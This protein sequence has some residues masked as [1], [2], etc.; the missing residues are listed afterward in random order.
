MLSDR[1]Q[2]ELKERRW[3]GKKIILAVSGGA[4]SMVM[5]HLF[6]G[7]GCPVAIAHCN[8]G[9]RGGESEGDESLVESWAQ[10]QGIPF[11]KKQFHLGKVLKQQGGNLQETA[12]E[13]RYCWFEELRSALG[14]DFIAVAHHQQDSIET[15][16]I[17][18]FKGTGI[19]GMH[20]ILP[21]Y[22]R[23][24]RPM[25]I[26]QKEDILD[27]A[28]R[29]EVLWRLD[30]SNKKDDYLR[31]KVRNRLLPLVTEMFPNGLNSLA[32][33]I[34]RFSEAEMLYRQSIEQYRKKLM[35]KR[36][37]DWYIPVLKLR[38]CKPLNTILYELLK[39]FGFQP[40]QLPQLL[41]LLD[42]GS[43][44]MVKSP[45]HRI[46]RDRDFLILTPLPSRESTFILIEKNPETE[47]MECPVFI[48][49]KRIITFRPGAW[50]QQAISRSVQEA[51]IDLNTLSF[52]LILR[53]WKQGD[54]F[55]PLGM[56]RKKKKVSR[57]LIDRK[58][59]LPEKE[60]VWVLESNKKIV[61]VVG[62]RLDERFKIRN[63]TAE[64]VCFSVREKQAGR[65]L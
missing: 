32:G 63:S 11:Y 48:L 23:I 59:S 39:P 19:S 13:Q 37:E 27:Y 10:Q 35:E 20:G 12:R 18:F 43:G 25:L 34:Q 33:N 7:S 28:A 16:L 2:A 56:G 57:F 60:N 26:F 8:Y 6:H 14:F 65:S 54:Y 61:W 5:A 30:S 36:N 58:L 3:L 53:P 9:L 38:H 29:N 50:D 49:E 4:D 47:K 46:I 31:N 15:M 42:A 45:T 44:K 51:F 62:M 22:G 17:N 41:H 21:E 40:A 55:Y 64:A 1:F 52:P 24:I